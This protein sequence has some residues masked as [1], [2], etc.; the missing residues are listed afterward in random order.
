M[1]GFFK[2]DLV[3]KGYEIKKVSIE[4]LETLKALARTTFIETYGDYIARCGGVDCIQDKLDEIYSN[5]IVSNWLSNP[6]MVCMGLYSLSHPQVLSGFSLLQIG[7]DKALL[8][9]LYLLQQVQNKGLGRLMM[10]A[11]FSEL[12][13]RPEVQ[14]LTLAVSEQ[15]QSAK[16]F[17]R[18]IGFVDTL[19]ISLY[20]QSAEDN[21]LYDNIYNKERNAMS[22]LSL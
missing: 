7:E 21:P 11:V 5:E 3:K 10:E 20:P 19:E 2:R 9:K 1:F 15:N 6:D 12:R 17:Y 13:Q 4:E 18:R 22:S 14:T 8:S 16:A